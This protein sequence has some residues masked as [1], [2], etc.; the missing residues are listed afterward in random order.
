MQLRFST[1]LILA[2]GLLA[3]VISHRGTLYW[4]AR[5]VV[6]PKEKD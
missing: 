3:M 6:P 1:K 5:G 2:M 4:R